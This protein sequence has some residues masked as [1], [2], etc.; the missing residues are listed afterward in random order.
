MRM[1]PFQIALVIAVV[2]TAAFLLLRKSTAPRS[3]TVR[4]SDIQLGPVRHEKLS[5]AHVARIRK[6]EPI[7]AEV[8]PR[9]HEGW[10]DGFQ[11]DVN[12]EPEVAIWEAMAAAYQDF[13]EKRA[14]DLEAKKE[15]FGLLL[16]RSAGDEQHTLSS[17]TLKHLSRAEA[18]E[19]LRLYSAA[20]QPVLYEKR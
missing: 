11:R 3:Q 10:L 16:V 7:F 17:A 8:Y 13:T 19:L 14:L 1:S 18:E 6:F 2:A 9:T 20:P 12:P 5:D 15:A 4:P